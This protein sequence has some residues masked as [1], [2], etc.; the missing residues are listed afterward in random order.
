MSIMAKGNTPIVQEMALTYSE[1]TT[2]KDL[3]N[4]LSQKECSYKEHVSQTCISMRIK[5]AMARNN[6][7]SKPL[8][9]ADCFKLIN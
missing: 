8:F 6:Y 2:L 5:R 9:L 4:N 3:A 7:T 1:L